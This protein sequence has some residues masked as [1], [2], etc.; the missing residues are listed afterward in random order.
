MVSQ[1][2]SIAVGAVLVDFVGYEALLVAA[3]EFAGV[4]LA[5][6]A[7]RAGPMG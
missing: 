6:I 2:A 3:C 7:P 5:G 4:G 1:T